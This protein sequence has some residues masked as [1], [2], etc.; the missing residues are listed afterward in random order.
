MKKFTVV[1]PYWFVR[2][3]LS[4]S[5]PRTANEWIAKRL[6]SGCNFEDEEGAGYRFHVYCK[7]EREKT[8]VTIIKR[9]KLQWICYSYFLF[10]RSISAHLGSS[11]NDCVKFKKCIWKR[12]HLLQSC[13][14][15]WHSGTVTDCLWSVI[16]LKANQR[17]H[18]KGLPFQSNEHLDAF[19]KKSWVQSHFSCITM[20]GHMPVRRIWRCKNFSWWDGQCY[21]VLYLAATIVICLTIWSILFA[22]KFLP[23]LTK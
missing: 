18:Q 8:G 19:V 16:F 1:S 20:C 9:I 4:V 14:W 15:L 11:K 17:L 7:S 23:T 6:M 12:K 10:M 22:G 2:S 3:K 21:R 5:Y 13:Q